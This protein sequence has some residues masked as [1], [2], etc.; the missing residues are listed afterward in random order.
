[1]G[2]RLSGKVEGGMYRVELTSD[3]DGVLVEWVAANCPKAATETKIF[4][5]CM[6]TAWH[7]PACHNKPDGIWIGS[8][9]KCNA[10][11]HT[12]PILKRAD[13]FGLTSQHDTFS[14]LN[15][16]NDLRGR[17]Y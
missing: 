10:E 8:S 13:V 6:R 17:L 3:G 1:E 5:W 7:W 15:F 2:Y 16:V 14:S 11:G 12:A 4:S 9:L